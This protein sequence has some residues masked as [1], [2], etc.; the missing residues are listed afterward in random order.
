MPLTRNKRKRKI[1][2]IRK[3][4]GR[5]KIKRNYRKLSRKG[6]R[7]KKK[8]N[9]KTKNRNRMGKGVD[10]E[11]ELKKLSRAI[12]KTEARKVKSEIKDW[13][14]GFIAEKGKNPDN[15]DKRVIHDKYVKFRNLKNIYDNKKECIFCYELLETKPIIEVGCSKKCRFHEKC[16]N[17][18]CNEKKGIVEI[19]PKC[20]N[21]I[22]NKCPNNNEY[23]SETS[24][25]ASDDWVA[26]H[27]GRILRNRTQR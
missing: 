21:E 11:H 3:T 4:R 20:Q 23:N 18:W 1:R 27:Q 25:I 24:S 2:S 6:G 12:L 14:D 26:I 13:V 16:F 10:E 15:N 9:T 7:R 5:R 17:D 8:K 22:Q 19:C